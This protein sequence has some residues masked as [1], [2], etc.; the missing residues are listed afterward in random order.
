MNFKTLRTIL[1]FQNDS[2]HLSFWKTKENEYKRK[3]EKTENN[4]IEIIVI[5][6]KR[7]SVQKKKKKKNNLII[8]I[9][10][11]FGFKSRSKRNI[12]N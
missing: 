2:K 6:R 4:K 12:P 11:S 3:G 7:K 10:R 5:F 8:I 9:T 1:I